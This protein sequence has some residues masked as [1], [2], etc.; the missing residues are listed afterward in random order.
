MQSDGRIS[1][2]IDSLVW[3]P[4][5]GRSSMRFALY[6][7]DTLVGYLEIQFDGIDLL[8]SVDQMGDV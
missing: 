2:A 5:Q 8:D 7:F 3:Q 6:N 4:S 1:G